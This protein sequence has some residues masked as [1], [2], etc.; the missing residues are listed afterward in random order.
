MTRRYDEPVE[1]RRRDDE[2]VAFLWRDR[3]WVVRAVLAHWVE[4]AAWWQ[5]AQSAQSALPTREQ[6]AP[7]RVPVTV[8]SAALA[9]EAQGLSVAAVVAAELDAV[10]GAVPREAGPTVAG[11]PMDSTALSLE[12]ELWR[13]EATRGRVHGSGVFDLCFDWS[14]AGAAGASGWTLARA[15]D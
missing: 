9:P 14:A 15:L 6:V 13:V 3:L 11:L 1:V 7:V 8:G 5:A 10:H 12:R 2:P 4:T